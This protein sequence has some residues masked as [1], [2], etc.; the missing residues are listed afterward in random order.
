MMQKFYQA[1]EKSGPGGGVIAEIARSILAEKKADAVLCFERGLD[2]HDLR[3][4]LLT[5]PEASARI[6]FGSYNPYGLARFVRDYSLFPKLAVF[7]RACDIRALV[8][9]QKRYQ[10]ARDLLLVGIYCDGTQDPRGK[11][12]PSCLR[13]EY[14]LAPTADLNLVPGEQSTLVMVNSEAGEKVLQSAQVTE[15]SSFE[16]PDWESTAVKARQEQE[17]Q[18]AALRSL[19]T[20]ERWAY[21]TDQF[22]RCIKCFGCRNSCPLCFCKDCYLEADRGLVEPGEVAPEAM[23]HLTRLAHVGDSC[24][25]CGQCELACPMD[26]PISLLYHMMQKDLAEVFAYTPGIDAAPPPLAAS[27]P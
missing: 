8:E 24:L 7:A 15:G 14:R 18:F 1:K 20:S 22:G 9:L 27:G 10:V 16:L 6:E 5:A 25:N 11:T 21:W 12:R 13:C 17:A 19:S 26:I 23:F 4:A 3:P 2:E